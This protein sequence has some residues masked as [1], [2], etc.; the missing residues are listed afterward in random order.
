VVAELD[1]ALAHSLAG[2]L[3]RQFGQTIRLKRGHDGTTLALGRKRLK[4]TLGR[5]EA[6]TD[7]PVTRELAARFGGFEASVRQGPNTDD[8]V[9]VPREGTRGSTAELRFLAGQVLAAVV[10]DKAG[11]IVRSVPSDQ[12]TIEVVRGRMFPYRERWSGEGVE[13]HRFEGSWWHGVGSRVRGLLK[14]ARGAGE[15]LIFGRR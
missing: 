13:L 4:L 9:L 5:L 2:Q 14:R 15:S 8:L 3:V 6:V 10:Y 11:S 7:D 12:V 1:E